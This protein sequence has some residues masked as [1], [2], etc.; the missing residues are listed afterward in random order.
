MEQF[1]ID[2]QQA[3][4]DYRNELALHAEAQLRY[5]KALQVYSEAFDKYLKEI[6]ER[7]GWKVEVID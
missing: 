1:A 6:I 4:L 7:N 5:V 2:Y 3:C